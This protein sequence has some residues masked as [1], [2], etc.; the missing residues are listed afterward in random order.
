[1]LRHLGYA[2]ATQTFDAST[3][4][5]CRPQDATPDL[6]RSLIGDNLRDLSRIV[7]FH[8][9]QGIHLYRVSSQVIPFASHPGNA[10]AWWDEFAG[11]LEAIGRYLRLHGLRLTMHPGQHTLLN[12]PGPETVALSILELGWHVRLFDAMQADHTHKLVLRVGGT[13][14]DKAGS[15]DR[16]VSVVAALPA[17]WKARLAVEN[18]DSRYR[19]DDVLE[20]SDRLGIPVVFDWV[21]HH[22]N[23]GDNPDPAR[24]IGLCFDTWKPNDGPPLVHFSSP[25]QNPGER[26]LHA[27]WVE[28]DDLEALLEHTPA[29]VPFDCLLEATQGDRALFDLRER[30][31][32]REAGKAPGLGDARYPR[33]F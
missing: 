10:I 20:V 29:D 33:V 3:T 19:V 18:D 30:M 5:T 6:V 1:M 9:E 21:H 25:S 23:P 8:D 7:R 11:D 16:F 24:L 27:D 31:A 32:L 26:I 15:L 22:A 4:R 17:S 13:F 2:A 12:A 28:P 14:G